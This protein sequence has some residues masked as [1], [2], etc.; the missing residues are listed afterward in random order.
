MMIEIISKLLRIL[1]KI[2]IS[3]LIPI[4]MVIIIYVIIEDKSRSTIE[5]LRFSNE[6]YN[7]LDKNIVI[8]TSDYHMFR[9]LSIAKKLG[10]KNVAGIAASS[11]L[12]VLPAYLLREYAAVMYYVLLGRM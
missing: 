12:S 5:N 7:L 10:Y 8:V 9:S 2:R 6:L 4:G 11:Q 3:P 1:K